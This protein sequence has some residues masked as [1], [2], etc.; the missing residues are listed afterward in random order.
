MMP[1]PWSF[2]GCIA[3]ALAV[4][5]GAFGAHALKAQLSPEMLSIWETSARYHVYHS[6]AL[7]AVDL[8]QLLSPAGAPRSP[9]LQVAGWLFVA[10]LILF[11]G[12]LYV[13]ALT[14]KRWLGAITPLG[15][16]AWIVG[17][18]CLAYALWSSRG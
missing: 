18:L 9:W 2:I 12:S 15:G 8:A 17:W 3:M 10:G 5:S 16:L 11:C 6:A 14:E 7:F 13:L 4:M 1:L